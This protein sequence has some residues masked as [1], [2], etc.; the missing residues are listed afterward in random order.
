MARVGRGRCRPEEI[1]PILVRGSQHIVE[2]LPEV[3]KSPLRERLSVTVHYISTRNHER[4][5]LAV[6]ADRSFE[7]FGQ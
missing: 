4:M 6:C 1:S 5:R 2:Y 7:M 3:R